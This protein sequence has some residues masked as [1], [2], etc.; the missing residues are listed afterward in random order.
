MFRIVNIAMF[1]R[2]VIHIA[3]FFEE[4]LFVSDGMFE[5]SLLPERFETSLVSAGGLCHMSVVFRIAVLAEVPFDCRNDSGVFIGA[6]RSDDYMKMVGQD[7][8]GV[9]VIIEAFFAVSKGTA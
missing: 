8:D 5:K 4:I 7:D 3:K 2:I 1:D 9:D 6:F